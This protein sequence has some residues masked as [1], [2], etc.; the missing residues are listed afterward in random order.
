MISNNI[1]KIL[2]EISIPA[3]PELLIQV[4]EAFEKNEVDFCLITR[5]ITQDIS[6]SAAILQVINS[7]F[8][9]M[10][11]KI[12]SIQQA[13]ALLGLKRTLM[14]VRAVSVRNVCKNPLKLIEFWDT[15]N[16]I[17]CICAE[18]ANRV[19][20]LAS[21]DA[22]SL[23]LFHVCGIPILME[24]FPDYAEI[25]AL[26]RTAPQSLTE[27]ENEHYGLNH[28]QISGQL[29]RKWQLSADIIIAVEN[30]DRPF[31][32]LCEKFPKY[33]DKLMMIAILKT[34]IGLNY[35]MNKM[36]RKNISIE[37]SWASDS[38]TILSF[39]G[40]SESDFV[41]FQDALIDKLNGLSKG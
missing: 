5:L 6:L 12:S 24:N 1:Q 13:I 8:F 39:L 9:G 23:G 41:L 7:P 40:V 31:S 29:C 30:H 3:R 16:D 17:A 2:T 15:A 36:H 20:Y 11:T 14:L 32:M 18:I 33:Q 38:K 35:E 19:N 34:A 28:A 4:T 10:R 26:A 25:Y 37:N 27:L 21:D 22:F